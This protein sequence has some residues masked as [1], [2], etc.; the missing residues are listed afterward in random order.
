[1]ALLRT[2]FRPRNII[3]VKMYLSEY[4]GE[5]ERDA[6]VENFEEIR[7]VNALLSQYYDYFIKGMP[8]ITVTECADSPLFFT[9]SAFLYGASPA[10]LNA[11]FY[12]TFGEALRAVYDANAGAGGERRR[13]L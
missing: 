7:R 13:G 6:R 5:Y 8:G 9:D 10:Y 12:A 3:L 2:R 4:R 1:M 11:G